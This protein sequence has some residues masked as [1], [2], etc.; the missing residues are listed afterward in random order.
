MATD[1]DAGPQST[2]L[3]R[4]GRAFRNLV[5]F[6]VVVAAAT[7]GLYAASLLNSRTWSLEV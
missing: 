5:I 4:L 1:S 2:F 6:A 7:G 3:R